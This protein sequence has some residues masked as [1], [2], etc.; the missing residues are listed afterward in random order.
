KKFEDSIALRSL[1][2]SLL[3]T[4][5]KDT[6]LNGKHFRSA[7]VTLDP[8]SSLPI[9]QIS[10]DE[11]GAKLYKELTKKNA[12]QR[13]AIFVGG[14]LVSAPMVQSEISG[15][16]AI[17]TGSGN[18][19]EAQ[20]LAQD[21]N[22][23]AIPAPIYLSGQNTIEATLGGEALR[24][25]LKAALI[26][27]VILMLYMILI[28]RFLGFLA[29]VALSIYALLFLAILKLP[30][31]LLTSQYIVLTLAGMAGI[32]LSMGMAVDANVLIFER[33]K[34][35]LR[36]GKSISTSVTI[37][38]KRAWPS[39][40]DG[41]AS[42]LLTCL[43]LFMIGTSIVRGF[44]VTLSMG[45]LMSMFTAITVTRWLIEKTSHLSIV[46]NTYFFVGIRTEKKPIEPFHA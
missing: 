19:D 8:T 26:G 24:T 5:W 11:E 10:F 18:F 12:G 25:S 20:N 33:I 28:Y 38:F 23:G 36:K 13:I 34:E 16:T 17:I 45:V 43:I 21:L 6:T 37:G 3:P 14:D 22:T 15:G 29:D 1:F 31:L 32:I 2:F 46:Q 40:R 44:S 39:I 4:G 7:G 27:V 9:V 30:L 42:T 35:E 41:N